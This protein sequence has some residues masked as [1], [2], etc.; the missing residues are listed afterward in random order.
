MRAAGQPDLKRVVLAEGLPLIR[1]THHHEPGETD[2]APGMGGIGN[3]H[4]WLDPVL[5][6]RMAARLTEALVE[7][8]PDGVAYYR[9]REAAYQA[10][11]KRLDA[12]IAAAVGRFR[13]RAYVSF[14][15]AWTYFG[16]RYGLA[17]AGV[18]EAAAGREPT[19]A[20]LEAIVRSVKKYAIRA[21][22]AEPQF[23]PRIAEAVAEN[24]GARVLFLDPL[25]NPEDPERDT[26]LE[27]MRYNLKVMKTGLE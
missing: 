6:G 16:R 22:F 14:H 12:E 1:E 26:Y 10:E 19:P 2:G 20:Q 8:D 5:A 18:I 21:V 7:I 23:S 15:P 13:T 9:Q 24:T 11:L 3:P 4:L 25:G 17:E 27:L